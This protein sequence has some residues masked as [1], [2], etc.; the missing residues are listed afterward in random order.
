MDR[1]ARRASRSSCIANR[2][3][4]VLRPLIRDV[5]KSKPVHFRLA[6]IPLFA[7]VLAG[8]TRLTFESRVAPNGDGEA[9]L[10]NRSNAAI[11]AY[12]FEVLREPC[13]PI[14]ANRHIYAGYDSAFAPSGGAV[15]PSASRTQNIGASHCN[16]DGAQS[17]ARAALKAALFADGTSF[18]DSQWACDPPPQPQTASAADRHCHRN[19]ETPEEKSDAP[20]NRRR[21]GRSNWPRFL[22]P[23]T[24]RSISPIRTPSKPLSAS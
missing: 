21:A 24:P 6:L 10:T 12:V 14:E 4:A 18:G 16:K 9:V 11:I 17:P 20:G 23:Q 5:Q 8:Q 13:N 22:H 3:C 19:T 15:Q 7:V 2:R 1:S